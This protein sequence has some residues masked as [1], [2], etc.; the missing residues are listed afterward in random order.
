FR[1]WQKGWERNI[2]PVFL[3]CLV[4]CW[5]PMLD[6]LAVKDIIV[7]NSEAAAIV[8]AKPWYANWIFKSFLALLPVVAGYALKWKRSRHARNLVG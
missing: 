5:W 1:F 6:W 7:P 4:A 3:G 2:W 8:V